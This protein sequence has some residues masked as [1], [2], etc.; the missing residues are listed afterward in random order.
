MGCCNLGLDD[1]LKSGSSVYGSA[2]RE[3]GI[4]KAG[5]PGKIQVWKR[6]ASGHM[7]VF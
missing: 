7:W 1:G 5:C 6:I 2:L 4:Q 3:Q